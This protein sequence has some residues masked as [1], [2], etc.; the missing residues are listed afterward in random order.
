MAGNRR[1]VAA[2]NAGEREAGMKTFLA[3]AAIAVGV[4]GMTGPAHSGSKGDSKNMLR[5]QLE[6]QQKRENK[7]VDK[8]YNEMM[9]R[10]R[11]KAKPYDPW[12]TVRPSAEDKK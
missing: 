12:Q 10:T 8:A 6:E 1:R 9:K 2:R 11:T 5:E 3:A 7:D 4:I